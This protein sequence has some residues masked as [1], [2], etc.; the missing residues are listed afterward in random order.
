VIHF[1]KAMTC[2]FA[3]EY[4]VLVRPHMSRGAAAIRMRDPEMRTMAE[5]Q[6]QRI[7]L[8]RVDVPEFSKL[9]PKWDSRRDEPSILLS[10]FVTTSALRLK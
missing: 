10:F 3:E 4:A 9:N 6:H 2:G 8:T 5:I 1:P 7:C